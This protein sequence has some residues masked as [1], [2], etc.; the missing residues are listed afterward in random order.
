M[1]GEGLFSSMKHTACDHENFWFLYKMI[2]FSHSFKTTQKC[3]H[4]KK[5]VSLSLRGQK[6][7]KKNFTLRL[8]SAIFWLSPVVL[9]VIISGEYMDIFPWNYVW[10]V[11]FITAYHFAAMYY[12]IKGPLL[13]V[14][15]RK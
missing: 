6:L 11:I 14:K 10:A 5:Q 3:P 1:E 9:I 4:C 7:L 8:L 15:V 13:K 12:I 2:N